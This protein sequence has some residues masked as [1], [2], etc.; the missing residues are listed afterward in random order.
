MATIEEDR[1]A[2]AAGEPLVTPTDLGLVRTAGAAAQGSAAIARASIP[3]STGAQPQADQNDVAWHESVGAGFASSGI[4][5]G[6][7]KAMAERRQNTPPQPGY[8]LENHLS[9]RPED[10]QVVQ[11]FLDSPGDGPS[12][13]I[14]GLL[15]DSQSAG[16]T[17]LIIERVRAAQ[18]EARIASANG[19]LPE[20]I[21]VVGGIGLDIAA[22][23]LLTRGAALPEVVGTRALAAGRLAAIGTV[24][25]GGERLAQQ[26][27]NPLVT[28]TDIMVAAGLGGTFSA[29]LGALAPKLFGNVRRIADDME[30]R[31]HNVDSLD[32]TVAERRGGGTA[33]AA[34]VREPT[35]GP[36]RGASSKVARH[37]VPKGETILRSPKRVIT[38]FAAKAFKD[39][40][41]GGMHWYDFMNRTLRFG[42]IN[43]EEVGGHTARATTLQDRVDGFKLT[44][45]TR[46]EAARTEYAGAMKELFSVGAAS[47]FVANSNAVP[48]AGKVRRKLITQEEY[49]AIADEISIAQGNAAVDV[50]P[51]E[52]AAKLTNEQ[53][54]TLL[55]HAE[56]SAAKDDAFFQKWGELEVEAGLIKP[57]ELLPGYR[58]QRWNPDEVEA[59]PQGFQQLLTEAFSAQPD[60]EFMKLYTITD[61]LGEPKPALAEGETWASLSKRDPE[62]ANEMLDDWHAAIRDD[63]VEQLDIK[64][65]AREAELKRL[66]G[67]TLQQ[68]EK[69][70]SE[71]RAKEGRLITRYERQLE[72]FDTAKKAGTVDNGF[73]RDRVARLLGQAEKRL[74]DEEAKFNVLRTQT[75]N[76]DQID[77]FIRRFGDNKQ[78]RALPKARKAVNRLG[79][80]QQKAQVRKLLSTQITEIRKAILN[81]DSPFSF[82]DNSDFVSSSSRMLRR[83]IHLGKER[84]SPL[85]RRML[86]TSAHDA[87]IAYESGVG[88]QVALRQTFGPGGRLVDGVDYTRRIIDQSL[89]G[90]DAKLQA[91]TDPAARTKIAADRARAN[92]IATRIYAEI[93]G[94]DMATN[95]K[96]F[97]NVVRV[98]NTASAAISL[99]GVLL[100]SM[101]DVAV[102]AMAGGKL[103]TGFQLMWRKGGVMRH[104]NEIAKDEGEMAVLMRGLS[105][106]EMGRFRAFA[107]LDAGDINMPGGRMGR[108][109][110]TVDDVAV[111]E[112]HA[113]MLNA[114][115][116]MVRG[117]FGLDFARQIDGH[118]ANPAKWS[119]SLRTFYAKLSIDAQTSAEIADFMNRYHRKYVGGHLRIPDSEKWIANGGEDLLLKYKMA[120]K[121][122]GDEAMLDPGMG[123]R[124]FMRSSPVG[125]LLLQ[126]QSFMFTASD[127]FIAPMIQEMHL[128][129]TSGRPYFGALGGM[130]MGS[131]IDGLKASIRGEGEQW[132]NDWSENPQENLWGAAIRSPLMAGGSSTIM[133][134]VFGQLGR[135]ANEALGGRVLPQSPNRFQEQQGIF[136]LFGPVVGTVGGTIPSIVRTATGG[137]VGK[138]ADMMSRRIP[139]MNTFYLQVL[140][141]IAA[142]NLGD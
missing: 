116:T 23:L 72:N 112:G 125:K 105:T 85:A 118:F 6:I 3:Q 91:T 141:R 32:A 55:R 104:I 33:G 86:K 2:A 65:S 109:M 7:S 124:P 53:R 35:Q 45:V 130:V 103:Q 102:M 84:H 1:Q 19:W 31:P 22:S 100:A 127:R 8:N 70:L 73:D 14:L 20:T 47:R 95:E 96:G 93:T 64:R 101:A 34:A 57:E 12:E 136:G 134:T 98:A 4:I 74:A 97:A 44:R 117:G 60:D 25:A 79:K 18:E 94:A 71:N 37:I 120:I 15:E 121:A 111:I 21:G 50:I 36:A 49:E 133:E 17:E 30:P 87:R 24:E 92:K 27:T 99:G 138:A 80:A 115:S 61:D 113:N 88:A 66:R 5:T 68:I 52:V 62:L 39:G 126:F 114:W 67:G 81:N 119:P 38:D 69:R 46:Q 131:M 82:L 122:A 89:E 142:D 59:D 9:E 106:L 26:I 137:D 54:E 108:I 51:D 107:E 48:F 40:D 110:R 140:G 11:Q 83:S 128:H 29:G 139:V 42:T 10:L 13:G 78:K 41:T 77:D 90:Y 56:A 28:N 63:A 76:I 135:N 75:R 43:A 123:D 129:P 16:E 132:L 58:P